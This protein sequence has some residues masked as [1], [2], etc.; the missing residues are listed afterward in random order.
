V[1]RTLSIVLAVA[2]LAAGCASTRTVYMSQ[3]TVDRLGRREFV[4]SQ[5][6]V[7]GATERAVRALG[8]QV[9]SSEPELGQLRTGRQRLSSGGPPSYADRAWGTPLVGGGPGAGTLEREYWIAVRETVP[10]RATVTANPY[11]HSGGQNVSSQDVWDL[12]AERLGW[13]AL[14]TEIAAQLASGPRLRGP[15]PRNPPAPADPPPPD[16]PQGRPAPEAD[17]SAPPASQ[18]P[19]LRPGREP[20][21]EFSNPFDSSP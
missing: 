8:L 17:W 9:V 1:T 3:E 21:S 11:L 15:A 14:F 7:F 10:G 12:H 16:A 6:E 5:D 18:P 19:A 2:W 13:N 20:G 4:A